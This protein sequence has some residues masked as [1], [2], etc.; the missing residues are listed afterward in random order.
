M[1]PRLLLSPILLVD[2]GIAEVQGSTNGIATLERDRVDREHEDRR[3][4]RSTQPTNLDCRS[5]L[6]GKSG[7]SLPIPLRKNDSIYHNSEFRYQGHILLA[8]TS[9]VI[10]GSVTPWQN[11]Y[12]NNPHECRLVQEWLLDGGYVCFDWQT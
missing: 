1:V 9:A 4:L 7:G 3:S 12:T 10:G 6:K 8:L 11:R 2:H 5:T